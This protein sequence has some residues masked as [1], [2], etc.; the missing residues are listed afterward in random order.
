MSS[1]LVQIEL[2]LTCRGLSTLPRTRSN[3]LILFLVEVVL[4][5]K[6]LAFLFCCQCI[7]QTNSDPRTA[8]G[9]PC[10]ILRLLG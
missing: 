3:H 2:E 4:C 6:S 9:I 8:C 10:I 7:G 5:P 1:L